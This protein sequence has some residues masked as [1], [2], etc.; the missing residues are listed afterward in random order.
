MC[1]A[2]PLRIMPLGDSITWGEPVPGGYRLPLWNLFAQAGYTIDYVGTQQTNPSN[3]LPDNDHQGMSGW[4]IGNLSGNIV[5]WMAAIDAPDAVLIHIGTNDS[6]AG[7]FANRIDQLDELV[8]KVVAQCPWAHVFVSTLLER[9]DNAARW[10]NISTLFNPFVAERVAAHQA[11]GRRVHFVDM[12]AALNAAADLTDGLHPNASGYVKMAATWFVAVTNVFPVDYAGS[13]TWTNLTQGAWNEPSNW[14]DGCVPGGADAVAVIARGCEAAAKD[15]RF[16]TI[17]SEGVTVGMLGY[18]HATASDELRIY[19]GPLRLAGAQPSIVGVD[20]HNINVYST[21]TAANGICLKDMTVGAP[22][23]VSGPVTVDG[24]LRILGDGGADSIGDAA[25]NMFPTGK[26]VLRSNSK[27]AFF[28][29]SMSGGRTI[30]CETTA[31]SPWVRLTGAESWHGAGSLVSGAGLPEGTFVCRAINYRLL[32]LSAPVP[33]GGTQNLVFAAAKG[34]TSFQRFDTVEVMA[35]RPTLAA[36]AYGDVGYSAG[37]QPMAMD[38]G[39]VVAP[40]GSSLLLDG[41]GPYSLGIGSRFAGGI[42]SWGQ[43]INL[44]LRPVEPTATT[45]SLPRLEMNYGMTLNVDAGRELSLGCLEGK[46]SCVLTKKGAGTLRLDDESCAGFTE[47]KKPT[48]TVQEGRL[49]LG[50]GVTS[51]PA[52]GAFFHVDASALATLQL[53]SENGTNFVERWNDVGGGTVYATAGT[54]HPLPYLTTDALNGK[55]VVDFGSLRYGVDQ[56]KDGYGAYMNWSASDNEVREVFLVVSDLGELP[57]ESMSTIVGQ[58]ML[59]YHGGAYYEFHRG[60]GRKL[61]H[62]DWSSA[63]VRGGLLELDG[64]SKSTTATDLP[65]GFHLVHLRTTGAV[66]A[67]CFAG[68]R[69]IGYGGQRLAEVI[70]YNRVLTDEEAARTTAYLSAKWFGF[71]GLSVSMASGTEINVPDGMDVSLGELKVSGRVVKSGGGT[72]RLAQASRTAAGSELVVEG[73]DVRMAVGGRGRL[74]VLTTSAGAE[75][76]VPDG[77]SLAL[78]GLQGNG[79]T[80]TKSGAGTLSFPILPGEVTSIDVRGGRLALTNDV[81]LLEAHL[82]VDI[83]DADHVQLQNKDGTNF[84]IR[85][86]DVGGSGRFAYPDNYPMCPWVPSDRTLNGKPFVDF[87]GLKYSSMA[88]WQR[89]GRYLKFGHR[90]NNSDRLGQR[91]DD[92]REVLMVFSDA[93]EVPSQA[94][95]AVGAFIVGDTGTYDFHR[96]WNRTMIGP[97]AHDCVR[98]GRAWLD[99]AAC[100]GTSTVIP[101]G[102]HVVRVQTTGNMHAGTFGMD[103]GT[104]QSYGGMRMAEA[105]IFN[106]TLSDDEGAMAMNY[107]RAKWLNQSTVATRTQSLASVHLAP[108][109]VFAFNDGIVSVTALSGAGTVESAGVTLADAATVTLDSD[110]TNAESLTVTGPLT[111][112]G[113]GTVVL[114]GSGLMGDLKDRTFTLIAANGAVDARALKNWSVTGEWKDGYAPKLALTTAGLQLSFMQNGTLLMLR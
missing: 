26:L 48:V 108:D 98:N 62:N 22:L 45:L 92:V 111:L 60:F 112:A 2:A 64:V 95:G 9:T 44:T 93:D 17:P 24:T 84:V 20:Y 46:T 52:S 27:I 77:A 32:E 72:L 88:N 35:G 66:H 61:F 10:Q 71:T 90:E 104:N 50:S 110:G 49:Q 94:E 68:D 113:S 34:G 114:S 7:D 43:N 97:W 39:E 8:L 40:A 53:R 21:I 12:C 82:H 57:P 106:R 3:E 51:E 78:R 16:L 91:Y 76:D 25:T 30:A 38:V 99:G 4:T 101:E 107:L 86:F 65:E 13:A 79:S 81:T 5:G 36:Y 1:A 89:D 103:R 37:A 83:S 14:Q 6:G 23:D 19:G 102:F 55:S 96:G 85:L 54:D 28:S 31:G 59:S 42:A 69:E 70:V 11:A 80:L 87:G 100:D 67:N 56:W 29:R 58:H 41:A 33:T 73:G 63:S 105:M 109:A 74:G 75:L 47:T 15:E 18:P